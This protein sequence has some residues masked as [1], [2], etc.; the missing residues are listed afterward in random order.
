MKLLFDQNLSPRLVNR[1]SDCYPS[2]LHVY[3]IGLDQADDSLLWDY[4]QQNDFVIV[5]G[6][7]QI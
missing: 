4:A 3:E 5:T 2:S 1:L 6:N 7:L